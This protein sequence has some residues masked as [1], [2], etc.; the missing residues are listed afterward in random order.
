MKFDIRD[1]R[2]E[3]F[4]GG[5]PGGQHRNKCACCIRAIHL[6]TGLVAKATSERSLSQ[7]KRAALKVLMGKLATIQQDK[8]SAARRARRDEKPEASFGSQIRTLRLCG[9]DQGLLDH[10]SKAWIP[11]TAQ[12]DHWFDV[13]LHRLIEAGLRKQVTKTEIF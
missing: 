7:N 4:R 3:A 8:E 2:F 9:N 11:V 1:V 13:D 10:R 6:P 12:G 5:G